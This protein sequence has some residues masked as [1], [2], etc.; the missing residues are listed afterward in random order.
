VLEDMF[1]EVSNV[2]KSIEQF[3]ELYDRATEEKYGALIIDLTDGK[4]FMKGLD[5]ILEIE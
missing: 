3:E 2:V 4:K 1:E 5:A